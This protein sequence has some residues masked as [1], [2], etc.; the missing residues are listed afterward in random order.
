VQLTT[1]FFRGVR[2]AGT[3]V[4]IGGVQVVSVAEQVAAV[5]NVFVREDRRG[6]GLAQ[7]VLSATVEAVLDVGIR[8]IGLNVKRTNAPA[9]RAYEALGF[10][11]ALVYY[12]G[13]ADRVS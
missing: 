11:R 8:T 12:E 3:L 5:G 7:T 6:R 9:V 2:D 13:M 4:A 10:R 1:G